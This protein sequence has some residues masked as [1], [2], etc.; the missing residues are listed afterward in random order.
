MNSYQNVK[1]VIYS[2]L[3]DY[4]VILK[5]AN[6]P[7]TFFKLNEKLNAIWSSIK[8]DITCSTNLSLKLGVKN[9]LSYFIDLFSTVTEVVY[10]NLPRSIGIDNYTILFHFY[11]LYHKSELKTIVKISNQFVNMGEHSYAIS[12]IGS[13]LQDSLKGLGDDLRHKLFF[14]RSDTADLLEVAY[15]KEYKPLVRNLIRGIDT[16]IFYPRNEFV[17]CSSCQ[18]NKECSWSSNK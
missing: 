1:S 10:Y 2:Q 6:Q 4:S 5:I 13:L 18:Y 14:F 8:D 15:N 9:K 12:L 7:V 17:V 11:S 16:R 3:F